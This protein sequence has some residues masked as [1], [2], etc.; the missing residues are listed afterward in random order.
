MSNL[1]VSFY[2]ARKR[3]TNQHTSRMNKTGQDPAIL[4]EDIVNDVNMNFME[5]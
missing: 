1:G 4:V 5:H 2:S 3:P